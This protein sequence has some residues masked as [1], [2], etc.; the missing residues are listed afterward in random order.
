MLHL[1]TVEA[2][3]ILEAVPSV[4]LMHPV[5]TGVPGGVT[6]GDSGLCCCVPCLSSAIVSL[7][8]LIIFNQA[9]YG[10]VSS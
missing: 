7:C 3:F 5:F 8:L 1:I 2:K 10:G 4:E 9:W 6:V